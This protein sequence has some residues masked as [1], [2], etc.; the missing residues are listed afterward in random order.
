MIKSTL[1]S[2]QAWA[3]S[4]VAWAISPVRSIQQK[5]FAGDRQVFCCALPEIL[6]P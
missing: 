6:A 1:L 4:Q 5:A 2:Q 3:A